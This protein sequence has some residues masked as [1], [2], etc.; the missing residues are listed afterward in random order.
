MGAEEEVEREISVKQ[1]WECG[2]AVELESPEE[3]KSPAV[4]VVVVVVE[5][6]RWV[7]LAVL[8]LLNASNSAVRASSCFPF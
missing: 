3:P 1:R 8:C 7:V 2:S 6:R 4:A 5:K